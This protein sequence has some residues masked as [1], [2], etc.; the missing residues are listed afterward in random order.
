MDLVSSGDF[1][2]NV[3]LYQDRAL[4]E[5]VV[6]TRNGRERLVL[7]SVDE[8]RRLKRLDRQTLSASDLTD[9]D[10][11]IIA[12]GEMPAEYAHLNDELSD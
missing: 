7:L 10:L 4:V 5:P 2:R 3:G 1:Q 9:E 12:A 8:Y 6:V 11:A